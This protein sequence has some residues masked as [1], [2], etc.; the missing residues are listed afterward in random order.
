M[1]KVAQCWDDGLSTDRRLIE[2]LRKYG[3]KATFNLTPGR[4]GDERVEAYWTPQGYSGWSCRGFIGGRLSKHELLETYSGFRV[5][6]HC[7]KHEHAG[8]IPD[9]S[10][11]RA[12]LDARHYLEDLFQQECPGF[13]W[14]YGA[15]TKPLAEALLAAGFEYGRTTGNCCGDVS[16]YEHPMLLCPNC[17]YQDC[18]FYDLYEKA[19]QDGDNFFYF[20]GHTYEMQDSEGMWKQLE[21]KIRFICDDPDAVWCDVIDI[22]R[23]DES[24]VTS[25]NI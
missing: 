25:A 2:M 7:M 11:I 17:H 20:W 18:A 10:F 9:E 3:A 12:A 19:K 5:A 23:N 14:P 8:Q 6:S 22:V 24:A 21:D 15:Y 13:A 4:H 16:Q 1:I